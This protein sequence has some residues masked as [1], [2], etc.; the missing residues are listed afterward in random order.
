[1]AQTTRLASFE[2]VLVVIILPVTYFVDRNL[3]IQKKIS[4]LI[5]K[6]ERKEKNLPRVQMT[7]LVSFGPVFIIVDLYVVYFVVYSLYT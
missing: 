6:G 3:Y 1:M 2:P 5:K 4:L 7:R